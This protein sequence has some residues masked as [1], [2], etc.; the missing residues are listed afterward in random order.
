MQH[1]I[2]SLIGEFGVHLTYRSIDK[3]DFYEIYI[4]LPGF[5]DSDID[6]TANHKAV[7]IKAKRVVEGELPRAFTKKFLLREPIN[8]DKVSAKLDKGILTVTVE[9]AEI[10]KPKTI[11]VEKSDPSVAE[12]V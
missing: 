3:G 5:D 8:T 1:F 9:K 12:P 11:K 2:N 7:L 6:I 4:E 10:A